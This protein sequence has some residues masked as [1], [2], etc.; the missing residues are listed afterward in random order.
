MGMEETP[1]PKPGRMDS[2]SPN[3]LALP[4]AC[5]YYASSP[6]LPSSLSRFS[7]GAVAY[8]ATTCKK[9]KDLADDK[10]VYATCIAIDCDI[11]VA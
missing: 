6:R 11:R 10:E 7:P 4:H 2:L 9:D 3:G 8:A 5:Q 1:A